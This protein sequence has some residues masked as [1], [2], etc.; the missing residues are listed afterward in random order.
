MHTQHT[1]FRPRRAWAAL[2]AAA[3]GLGTLAAPNRAEA[4]G[5]LVADGGFGGALEIKDH[6]VNVVINN[7]VA[8]TTVTQV[9]QNTENRQVEAL[10]TFPVPKGG[11][12]S[13]FCMWING[14]EMTGEVLEKKRAREIYDSYKQTRRDP[15]LLEQT[16]YR[17]FEMRV[18]PIGPR[19]EQKVQVTYAQ[20]LDYDNDWATYVYPLAT[21]TRKD[22]NARTT[23]RFALTL[24]A[25][26]E[27]PIV[28]LESPSHAKDFAV[29]KHSDNYQQASLETTG[30]D[31]GRDVVLAFHTLRPKTGVDMI[32]SKQPGED[33]YFMLTVT[34]GEELAAQNAG[35]DYVFILDVSGSMNEGGKLDLS[36]NALGA[37]VNGLGENDRVE[38]MAFNVQP[39]T[40]FQKLVDA[41]EDAKRRAAE[42]LS[43]QA[44]RGGTRLD[45]AM[46][47]A[48]RYADTER[49]LN[50]VLLSDGLTEQAGRAELSRIIKAR[51]QNARVFC[52]GVGNDVD[53]ALLEQISQ[54]TG[55]LAAFVSRQDNFERQAA[56]FRRKLLRPVASDVRVEFAGVE[57][58]DLEPKTLPNLY[59]GMP[60]RLYGRYRGDGDAKVTLKANVSGKP[61]EQAVNMNFP[62]ADDANPQVER[63]WAWHKV[64]RL[65]KEADAGGSRTG[66]LDEIVRLGEGYSIA[67]EYT[68]FIVLEND[69]EY[70]RW[71]IDRRNL[72]RVERDKAARQQV[73]RQLEA[74]RDR[75]AL[76]IGPVDSD[77]VKTALDATRLRPAN[78]AQPRVISPTNAPVAA[79]IPAPAATP[80]PSPTGGRNSRDLDL[81]VERRPWGGGGS[82]GGGALDPVTGGIALATAALVALA[83]RRARG[84]RPTPPTA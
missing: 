56:A 58:Y 27:V 72:L 34:A 13:N 45:P 83:K 28:A 46:G 69:A 47:A 52:I 18:F 8:V 11:S 21:S 36:R 30:G 53:R 82:G 67:T 64:D 62:K 75:S 17:T 43:S 14:K 16:N 12:V 3:L 81:P 31:L 37:F 22:V 84:S 7:G 33:G 26:S 23:G 70:R 5:L 74:L 20:E 63:M 9:F 6:D 25:K 65:L 48:Y 41:D 35:M 80:A 55:G 68:S 78:A 54:D 50:V 40:L 4:A 2:A 66:V 59:H 79:P 73:A 38:V 51:P 24:D 60:V 61:I 39:T 71:K 32:T 77:A 44:A 15:G 57:A 1:R 76:A 19:A 10:Y 29:A 49:A 42:F